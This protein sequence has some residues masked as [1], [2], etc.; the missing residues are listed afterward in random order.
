MHFLRWHGFA[1]ERDVLVKV[2]SWRPTWEGR[3]F[4][5]GWPTLLVDHNGYERRT[6]TPIWF[7]RK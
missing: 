6:E 3:G 5:I 7:C 4:E 1:T 2:K